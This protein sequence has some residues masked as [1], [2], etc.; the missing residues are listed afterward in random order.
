MNRRQVDP[1]EQA[2]LVAFRSGRVTESQEVRRRSGWEH[3]HA[4]ADQAIAAMATA[5]VADLRAHGAG[6]VSAL[7]VTHADCERLADSIRASL[8]EDGTISGPGLEGPGWA[9]PRF[10]R[11]G[12]RVLLHAHAQLDD[13]GR[14]TNGTVAT[15]VAAGP[16]GLSVR[17][18]RAA[19]LCVL[20]AAFVAGRSGDGRPKLSH[21]W[22]RTVDGVQGGT[23]DHVHLF[24]TPAIDRYRGYVGQSRSRW[25]TQT[26][27]TTPA[28][29]DDDHGGVIVGAD[30]AP[31]DAVAA[32]LGRAQPKTFAAEHDPYRSEQTIRAE[33][34]A[35][36]CRL[37]QRPPD[38]TAQVAHAQTVVAGRARDVADAEAGLAA[39]TR[40]R[41]TTTGLRGVT[42]A[43]RRL[44][45]DAVQRSAQGA[46]RVRDA[47]ADLAAAQDHLARLRDQ[48]AAQDHLARLRDQAAARE[49]FDEANQWR[50]HRI[51]QLDDQL[52][53]QWTAAVVSAARDG[54]PHAYGPDHLR[55]ARQ[56]LLDRLSP[57]TPAGAPRSDS[58][59]IGDPRPG[60]RRPRRRRRARR[61]PPA[62]PVHPAGRP[63]RPR[64]PGDPR[65]PPARRP[66][67]LP[68]GVSIPGGASLSAASRAARAANRP[69]GAA[70]RS[71]RSSSPDPAT[72]RTRP[73]R[74]PRWSPRT[75]PGTPPRSRTRS[76]S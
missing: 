49:A 45:A 17:P 4:D 34:A 73:P 63:S 2:A 71:A 16:D 51:A 11:A 47:R 42:P 50:H 19:E 58:G 15:V 24:A 52:G 65:R 59:T 39:W 18:D 32:A 12:D 1:V 62:L 70:A 22:A 72:G 60:A 9:G 67:G 66:D 7:A 44:H 23:W 13:G 55:A 27:N 5:V 29:G 28:A 61:H 38:V 3:H 57:T 26:W 74:P 48:A 64:R 41:D 8:T 46:V 20:P 31:A 68:R 43:R 37:Q 6:R 14:L 75:P 76:V 35:H 56:T 10:Y 54:Y 25:P 36:R 69:A 53:E 33:Q 30:A 40:Q 21:A